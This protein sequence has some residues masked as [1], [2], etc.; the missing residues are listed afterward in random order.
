MLPSGLE[1]YVY[2]PF[3][4][5]RHTV[6]MRLALYKRYL[7]NGYDIPMAT[8][9]SRLMATEVGSTEYGTWRWMRQ[10]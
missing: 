1:L 4:I 8:I 5:D 10:Q 6:Y 2:L 7:P 3:V 9:C